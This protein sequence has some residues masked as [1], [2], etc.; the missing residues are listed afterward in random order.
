MKFVGGFPNEWCIDLKDIAVDYS[1]ETYKDR[2]VAL[3]I[4]ENN[5]FIAYME[6]PTSFNIG[7]ENI[8]E[9]RNNFWNML[10]YED[11]YGALVFG[12]LKKGEKKMEHLTL[13]TLK[14]RL[15][16][17]L[18]KRVSTDDIILS[19]MH[20]NKEFKREDIVSLI[21]NKYGKGYDNPS[22]KKEIADT[23]YLMT[24]E[25]ILVRVK[26]GIYAIS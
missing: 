16:E 2:I 11:R 13:K 21:V 10:R 26:R 20:K 15:S 12:K 3:I 24:D 1:I 23:L 6:N 19:V 14:S 18:N 25:G 4:K 8:E 5:I 22:V 7:G 9:A 17:E